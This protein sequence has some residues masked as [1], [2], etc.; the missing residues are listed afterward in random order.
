MCHPQVRVI[1]IGHFGD[2][3]ASVCYVEICGHLCPIL[4]FVA[5]LCHMGQIADIPAHAVHF[6]YFLAVFDSA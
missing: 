5:Q 2:L 1:V 3:S 4:N 6:C